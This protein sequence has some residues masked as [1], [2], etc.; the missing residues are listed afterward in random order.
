MALTDLAL[1]PLVA[2]KG[3]GG[4]VL[5]LQGFSPLPA[6]CTA[7]LIPYRMSRCDDARVTEGWEWRVYQCPSCI[8]E[9]GLGV[10]SWP[11][12]L[13]S[14]SDGPSKSDMSS[15]EGK[16]TKCSSGGKDNHETCKCGPQHGGV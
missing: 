11:W 4:P 15:F 3:L 14:V 2:K 16:C 10:R 8:R 6:V 7:S 1:Q 12:K 13:M 9:G 5:D